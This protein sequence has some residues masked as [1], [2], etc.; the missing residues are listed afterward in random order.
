MRIPHKRIL[1]MQKRRKNS[2]KLRTQV[3]E[4]SLNKNQISYNCNY[5]G[6]IGS[7]SGLKWNFSALKS[8]LECY[9]YMSGVRQTLFYQKITIWCPWT[10]NI[11]PGTPKNL[12]KLREKNLKKNFLVCALPGRN[13]NL[14][15]KWL[16][17]DQSKRP[18]WVFWRLI[19]F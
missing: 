9:K 4:W 13:L 18:W 19:F 7:K 17:R 11:W 3:Q 10:P 14:W 6:E 8:T 2:K 1:A 15:W 16:A 12:K 5:Q